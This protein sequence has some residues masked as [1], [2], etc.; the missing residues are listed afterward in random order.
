MSGIP[1]AEISEQAVVR[2]PSGVRLKRDEVRDRF[3]LL[4]PERTLVMDPIGVAI[5]GEIDGI[6]T[7]RQMIDSLASAYAADP[8]I[9]GSDVKAF[10]LDLA[11]RR[12]LEICQ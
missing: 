1:L 12:I 9:I 3:V 4:A 5:L 6:K 2:L 8:Q 11:S 7:V 10:L